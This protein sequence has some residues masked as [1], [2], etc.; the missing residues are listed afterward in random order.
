M[1]P[2]RIRNNRTEKQPVGS[3]GVAALIQ[4]FPAAATWSAISFALSARL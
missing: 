4:F 1:T 2:T 3:M